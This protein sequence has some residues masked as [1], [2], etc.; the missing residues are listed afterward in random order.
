MTEAGDR[1]KAW[2]VF[3]QLVPLIRLQI[4]SGQLP[5]VGGSRTLPPPPS[6]A[7][8]T[9]SVRC[10][11][12]PTGPLERIEGGASLAM[13]ELQHN[14]S[15][16]EYGS[17]VTVTTGG[18]RWSYAARF[19]VSVPKGLSRPC[20]LF[21]RARVVNGQIG[22]AIHD[23]QT[24]TEQ[25]EKAVDPSP[26]M[27]DIYV[28][29]LFPQTADALIVRNVASGGVR[30]EIQ[31]EDVGLLAFLKPLPEEVVRVIALDRVQLGDKS[32]AL[33]QN[34]D[35]LIVTTGPGM[36]AFAGRVPLGI[37]AATAGALTVHLR[38]RVLEGKAGVG[39]LTPANNAFILERSVWP[40]PH[41]L[42]VVLA[43]PS[44]P[45]TGDL[46]VRNLATGNVASKAMIEKIEIRRAP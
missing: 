45:I 23:S 11:G 10:A 5:R 43:L 18:Q 26:E 34:Q 20:Y 14:G 38:V 31:I 33:E 36:G 2:I 3:Q 40:T 7:A 22:L 39:V 6:L 4:E 8:S 9:T 25:L 42:D 1:I 41:M 46:I 27:S 32:A 17:P 29:I 30:S 21:L 24:K 15:T 12:A 28:P 13:V 16:V 19:A 44:P 37:D 35:G